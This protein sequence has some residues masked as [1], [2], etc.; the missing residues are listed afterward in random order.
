MNKAE[1]LSRILKKVPKLNDDQRAK[2]IILDPML[3]TMIKE[4]NT[5]RKIAQNHPA[6]IDAL[7]YIMNVMKEKSK[8]SKSQRPGN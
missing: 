1:N 2:S 8:S 3:L 6:L 7:V 5:L 4:E